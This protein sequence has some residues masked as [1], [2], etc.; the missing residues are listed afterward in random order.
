MKEVDISSIKSAMAIIGN[1]CTLPIIACL[2]NGPKRFSELQKICVVC[3]RTLSTRLDELSEN[4]LVTKGKL[5]EYI[6]TKKGQKLRLV[7]EQIAAW[8]A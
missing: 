1:K 8:E 3:P 5:G 2:L 7:I 4:G 6:L